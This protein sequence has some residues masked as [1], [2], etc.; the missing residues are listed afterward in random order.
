MKIAVFGATG[1]V[2]SAV[3]AEAL[4]RGHEVTAVS[5][6][7]ANVDQAH[8]QA[9]DFADIVSVVNTINAHDVSLIAIAGRDDY[10]AIASAH[11]ALVAAKPTGRFIV[12]G[13]AG[14]LEVNGVRLLDLPDFPEEYRLE[15]LTFARVYETYQGSPAAVNWTLVAP[16]PE[17]APGSRTGKYV[18][19]TDSPVGDYV[20]TQYFAVAIVDEMESPANARKRFTV[21]SAKVS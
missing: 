19:G 18:L 12:V 20:S 2:G 13:G 17:I 4:T 10:E 8:G 1:M 15:A 6:S 3:T 14:A 7:G 21:A 11:E 5:R 9:L 16:S